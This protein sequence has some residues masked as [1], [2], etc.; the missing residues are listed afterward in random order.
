MIATTL[1]GIHTIFRTKLTLIVTVMH[2]SIW[3]TGLIYGEQGGSAPVSLSR[4]GNGIYRL[5]IFKTN[6]L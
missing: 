3:T 6:H 4:K 5:F 1:F 2:P